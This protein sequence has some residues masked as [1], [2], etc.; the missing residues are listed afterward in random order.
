MNVMCFVSWVYEYS[1]RVWLL[2]WQACEL[3]VGGA[4]AQT[5]TGTLTHI[6]THTHTFKD[7]RSDHTHTHAPNNGGR[8]PT[9]THT[10]MT[11]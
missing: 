6:Q 7:K 4:S 2:G 1:Y 3:Q 8:I 5:R 9:H 10:L 11:A